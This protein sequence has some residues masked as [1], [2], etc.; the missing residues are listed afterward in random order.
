MKKWVCL[1]LC[2]LL[3]L[4]LVA[5]GTEKSDGQ[6]DGDAQEAQSANLKA[7]AEEALKSLEGTDN[8]IRPPLAGY[9]KHRLCRCIAFY[10]AGG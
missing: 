6:Q 3:I 9:G 1:L 10:R 4:S 5:C 8:I 2:G 7:A